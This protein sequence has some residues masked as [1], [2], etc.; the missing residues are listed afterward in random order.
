MWRSAALLLVVLALVPTGC[1]LEEIGSAAPAV[2]A[3]SPPKLRLLSETYAGHQ[4]FRRATSVAAL[5]ELLPIARVRPEAA[6]AS[7]ATIDS[8]WIGNPMPSGARDVT[9]IWKSGVV[10]TFERW[11]CNCEATAGLRQ[12]GHRKPFRFLMLRGAPAITAPS[13][14][15][16]N[17]AARIGPSPPADDKYGVPASVDT[18][19]DGYNITLWEYGPNVQPGLLALAR[20]LPVDRLAL[21][22]VGYEAAGA[23]LGA[24]NGR[25][26]ITVAPRGGARFGIGV[27]LGNISGHPLTITGVRVINGFIRLIG[28]RL[29]PYTL[30]TGDAAGRPIVRQPYDATPAKLDYKLGG[31]AWAGMQLDY[32]VMSPCIPWASTIYEPSAEVDYTQGGVAHIQDIRMVQLNITRHHHC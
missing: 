8:V 11:S 23:A 14:P 5:S 22:A 2:P 28:V 6:L 4:F 26:G 18:I 19:R 3:V 17:M 7:D 30:P 20:T 21:R 29:R 24:W 10:E 1:S 15:G 25:H 16:A 32:Q 9:I 27:R 13:D 31:G 12:V